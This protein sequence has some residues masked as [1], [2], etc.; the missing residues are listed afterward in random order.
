VRLTAVSGFG[1]KEPAAFLVE[2]GGVRLLLDLGEGPAPGLRPDP[3][4]IG[5]LDG[6]VLSHAHRDHCGA[7]DLLDALG[8]PVVHATRSVLDRLGLAEGRELPPRGPTD[9]C[10]IPAGTGRAGHAL[11]GVWVRLDLDGGLLYMG[12][13]SAESPCLAFDPPPPSRAL[14]LDASY[15]AA[16]QPLGPQAAAL[17]A[18]AAAG[19]THFPVPA[20]GR[21]L[22]MALAL[23]RAGLPLAIDAALRAMLSR[24][25]G[26][27]RAFARPG[28][29]EAAAALAGSAPQA[30]P[31]FPGALLTAD[32]T[33]DSGLSADLI[34]AR[35][36]DDPRLIVFTG[37]LDAASRGHRLVA[38]GRARLLRWNVHP[39]LP[40]NAALVR[41]V[42]ARAVLPAFG[43]PEHRP[44]LRAAFA[45]AALLP[46]E[47]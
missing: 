41:A 1:P 40:E 20:D 9:I 22:D 8:R 34:A 10:G 17:L 47:G 7:L 13:H 43:G 46:E 26:P 16:E 24:L 33:G 30:E 35:R 36:E 4:A 29:A 18:L 31:G 6:L 12:D 27:D 15:G 14:V 21:G 32:A 42:G 25:A 3:D 19:P 5:R 38:Q 39:T 45:P 44:R 2:A 37:H 28:A 11:G 23:A